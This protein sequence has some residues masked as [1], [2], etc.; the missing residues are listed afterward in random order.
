M[1]RLLIV[2]DEAGHRAGLVGLLRILK[3]EYLVFEAENGAVALKMMDVMDFDLVL[4]DIRMPQ[5][6]GLMFLERAKA[7]RPNTRIAILSA[8]GLFE[9]ARKSIA[10]GADDYL[11]KPV[12][13]EELRECLNRMENQLISPDAGHAESQMYLFV[14]GALPETDQASMRALFSPYMSGAVL[15]I[16]PEDSWQDDECRNALQHD[17][18]QRLK[19]FGRPAVFRTAMERDAMIG[20]VA[21]DSNALPLISET[22]ECEADR[23][24]EACGQRIVAGVCMHP[25]TFLDHLED[26][27]ANA[28][29]AC[30]RH[31][32]HPERSIFAAG[33]EHAPDP[34]TPMRMEVSI[35]EL[36][37]NLC[38]GDVD[39]AYAPLKEQLMK[40]STPGAYPSKLK[41]VI[42]YTFIFLLG[43]LTFPLSQQD[44][45]EILCHIDKTVLECQTMR[46]ML[47]E[48]RRALEEIIC[49]IE[50]SRK[51]QHEEVFGEVLRYM[52]TNFDRDLSLAGVADR[53]HY[54]PSYFS[55][56]FK[57]SVGTTFS[58]YLYGLRMRE[59]ARLLKESKLYAATIGQKVGY[60]GAAYF[61][62]AF[63]KQ[64]G[65]S[66]DQYR[67]RGR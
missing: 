54:H 28:R 62:K 47:S 17:L 43:N 25:D 26:T 24:L 7:K 35:K 16:Q 10:L 9:Y 15:Y 45:D 44:K 57:Q 20:V 8:Y 29:F 3:P 67:K 18:R 31:F 53:F 36:D 50:S 38:G 58:D 40:M 23:L 63:K 65:M 4:T 66:P 2:D 19:R 48:V 12:D 39:R 33:P 46:D 41:E 34:F 32:F 52:E 13:A 59:A 21:C 55:T 37:A 1:Y 56:L 11:L 42:M 61:T 6:D 5:I 64:Y 49:A 30:T 22:L 60:P 51:N 14:T 27:Y